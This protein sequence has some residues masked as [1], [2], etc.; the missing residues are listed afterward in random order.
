MGTSVLASAEAYRNADR[1][2]TCRKMRV[3]RRREKEKAVQRTAFKLPQGNSL[4]QRALAG[5]GS[6]RR[7]T[8]GLTLSEPARVLGVL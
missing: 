7:M 6:R 3:A 1:A 4:L 8:T 2:G 5:T